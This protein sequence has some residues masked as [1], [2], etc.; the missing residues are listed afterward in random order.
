M[1]TCLSSIY[2]KISQIDSRYIRLALMVFCLMAS[3]GVVLGIP[4]HGDVGG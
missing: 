1:N 2:L 4:I 3:G